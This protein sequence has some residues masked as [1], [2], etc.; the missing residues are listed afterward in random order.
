MID[1]A[2]TA[3]LPAPF[4][5]LGVL[6]DA[7]AVRRIDFLPLEGALLSVRAEHVA[8]GLLER[9]LQAY[10]QDARASLAHI[11]LQ[12]VGT[13]YQRR[14]WQ[15]L[16]AIPLGRVETYGAVASDLGSGARAV[17]QACG[18]NPLPL[19]IPCHRVVARHGAGGFMQH[20]EGAALD[21]KHWLLAH[22][23]S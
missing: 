22:E 8:V 20:R 18:A 21:Y 13:A 5:R 4:A 11:P 9:A 3:I 14:V 10:W 7:L 23:S 17:G 1:C 15:A 6:G 12:I 2:Y 19:I 16:Q